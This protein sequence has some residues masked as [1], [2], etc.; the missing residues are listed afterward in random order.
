MNKLK[1][2]MI[3]LAAGTTLLALAACGGTG[4]QQAGQP[5]AESVQIHDTWVKAAPKGMSAAFGTL[6]NTSDSPVTITSVTTPASK[7]VQLHETVENESGQ[8]VMREKDGGFTIEPGKS[9]DLKPGA[10]HIMLMDLGKPIVSGDNVDFVVTFTDDSTQK[11]TAPAKDYSGAN[12]NYSGDDNS[13]SM[14][15]GDMDM[16]MGDGASMSGTM[17]EGHGK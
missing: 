2:T 8:M 9:L 12:E 5:Q 10:D 4:T 1:K 13:S 14:D 3:T 15:H 11:F 17:D 6:E 16:D 7:E